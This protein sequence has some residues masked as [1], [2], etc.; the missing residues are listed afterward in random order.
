MGLAHPHDNGGS[1]TI[2]DDVI[3]SF[4]SLGTYNANLHP[5]TIMSYNDLSESPYTPNTISDTG[6]METFGPIDIY[7]FTII[8]WQK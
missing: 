8:I 6:F 3:L 1:S 4:G 5:F 7:L 2:Y